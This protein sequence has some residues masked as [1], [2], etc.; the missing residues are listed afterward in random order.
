MRIGLLMSRLRVEEKWLMAAL[1]QRG[2]PLPQL[3]L[4]VAEQEEVIY[5]AQ[6]AAA[7]QLA[8]HGQAVQFGEQDVQQDQIWLVNK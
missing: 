3:I 5:E 2:A 6:V 1:D 7:A 8:A 4:I